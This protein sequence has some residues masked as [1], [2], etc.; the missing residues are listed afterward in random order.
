MPRTTLITAVHD[1]ADLLP[2]AIE[3]ALAQTDT[4]FELIV[5]DDGSTDDSLAVAEQ[6][7]ARGPRTRVMSAPNQ[8]STAVLNAA[9][10]HSDSP[11]FG[12]VD[13]DDRIAR[14]A[15][16]ETLPI[17]EADPDIGLVFTNHR[18]I[19]R[20]GV[21]IVPGWNTD[22]PYSPDLLMVKQMVFHFRL[23]SREIFNETGGYDPA[24][25]HA[26][27]YDMMLRMSEICD[28]VKHPGVLYDYR[29]Y[30]GM[31]SVEKRTEQ[32]TSSAH[33][34]DVAL[35][36]RGVSDGL[37]LHVDEQGRFSLTNRP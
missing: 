1:R 2:E 36:R 25:P 19:D 27:D 5:W 9:L 37:V 32:I 17:I 11:Y 30:D 22:I 16:A 4:D 26:E 33:A 28:I 34:M 24:Y 18:R 29:I 7:A 6:Y 21:D 14:T 35:K 10:A 8:G 23:F 31:I 15:L 13:S 12:L 20:A 3:S